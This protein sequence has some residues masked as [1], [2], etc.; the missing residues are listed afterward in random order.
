MAREM[1][2][3]PNAVQRLLHRFFMLRP[4]SEFFAPRIHRLDN[5]VLKLTWGRYT[6]V[7]I[8]GW[9]VIQLTTIGA[10]SQQPRSI[11]LVG[12]FDCDKIILIASSFGRQ[13]N[14]GWY[15]NLKAHPEGEVVFKGKSARYTARE[16]D[17]SERERYFQMAVD[18]YAGYRN[19][20][21]WASHRSIPVMLLEPTE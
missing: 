12:I 15:Y 5:A 3:Q 20:R 17:G 10:K 1:T 8:L 16:T 11:P 14:P 6:A 19:Y 9:Y 7:E 2:H 21:E 4:V 13:H 18:Q